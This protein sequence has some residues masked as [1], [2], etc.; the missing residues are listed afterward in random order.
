M[1]ERVNALLR[2][3]RE[4]L[5]QRLARAAHAA[6][7]HPR[8]ARHRRRGR[9]RRGAP[10]DRRDR[11]GLGRPRSPRRDA[12]HRS[13][14]STWRSDPEV[15]AATLRHEPLDGGRSPSARPPPSAACIRR[16]RSPS[17][18]ATTPSRWSP[19]APCCA[20]CSTTCSTTPPSTP[21]PARPSALEVRRRGDDVEFVVRDQGIGID[22]ADLPHLFEPFFRSDRTRTRKT[23][24]VGPRAGAG[25]A[26]RRGARRAHRRREPRRRR[27][28]R[29]LQRPGARLVSSSARGAQLRD[30]QHDWRASPSVNS[31]LRTRSRATRRRGAASARLCSRFVRECS[32]S[33]KS[34]LDPQQ[35]RNRGGNP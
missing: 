14:A 7:A 20:A 23:G 24:G 29:R 1:A 12:A 27:H 18:T 13:R 26:H 10:V 2:T 35:R 8:R 11:R 19:T 33:G 15:P 16:T 17:R 31:S 28:H 25:Q 34:L 22:A 5:G 9:H 32:R 30:E 3:Q 4:F 21:T 6:G